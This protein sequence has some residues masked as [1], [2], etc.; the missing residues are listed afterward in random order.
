MWDGLEMDGC[1]PVKDFRTA[2]VPMRHG[3]RKR[4]DVPKRGKAA[5]WAEIQG[6]GTEVLRGR[7]AFKR[8]QRG[9]RWH[10]SPEYRGKYGT[11]WLPARR[12]RQLRNQTREDAAEHLEPLWEMEGVQDEMEED[13]DLEVEASEASEVGSHGSDMQNMQSFHDESTETESSWSFFSCDA[14]SCST[15]SP[16]LRRAG[17]GGKIP[18]KERTRWE[19][20]LLVAELNA[21]IYA[22]YLQQHGLPSMPM[23]AKKRRMPRQRQSERRTIERQLLRECQTTVVWGAQVPEGKK[24]HNKQT[25]QTPTIQRFEHFRKRFLEEHGL[26]FCT[27]LHSSFGG[28]LFLKPTPL[29]EGVQQKFLTATEELEGKLIPTYHGT[30]EHNLPSIFQR[31][32]LVPYEANNGIRVANGSAHGVGIYTASMESPQLSLGFIRP[33]SR[34]RQLL[35]CGVLDDAVQSGELKSFG[36]LTVKAESEAVRHVGNAVVI[37]DSRRVAP[38]FVASTNTLPASKPQVRR[39]PHRHVGPRARLRKSRDKNCPFSLR[40]V[41]LF[42]FLARRGACKRRT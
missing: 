9:R 10:G 3:H 7:S 20:A 8:G 41:Q 35:V 12:R 25:K 21:G 6:Q 30:S 2:R 34:A 1:D 27:H 29:A 32:L 39:P 5:L 37:F 26:N 15:A 17:S 36:A 38:L 18:T 4:L 31:G 42:A 11:M 22:A 16:R 40:Q 13:E 28:P 19:L 33:S 23:Q 24:K 14:G